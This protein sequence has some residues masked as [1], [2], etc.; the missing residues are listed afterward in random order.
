MRSQSSIELFI[1]NHQERITWI[2]QNFQGQHLCCLVPMHDRVE[3]GTLYPLR[4]NTK[5]SHMCWAPLRGDFLLGWLFVMQGR[6]QQLSSQCIEKNKS[7]K[8]QLEIKCVFTVGC[9][10]I[11]KPSIL[12]RRHRGGGLETDD[13]HYNVD[14]MF[15]R[16]SGFGGDVFRKEFIF[17]L[18]QWG[19]F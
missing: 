7:S 10:N 15:V 5:H 17:N 13:G 19:S 16:V 18:W 2:F 3:H 4:N 1:L 6:I 9:I 8:S 11:N 12:Q 14:A